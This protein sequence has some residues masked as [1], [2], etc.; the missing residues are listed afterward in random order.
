MAL[1]AR[2]R[3]GDAG[4]LKSS[5]RVGTAVELF[6]ADVQDLI[7]QDVLAPNTYQTYRYQYDKNLAPRVS[8][9]RLDELTTPRINGVIKAI[10]DEVG[11]ATA[12]TCRTIVSRTCALAVTHGALTANPVREITIR[13]TSKK[14]PPRALEGDEL[15]QWF[16]LL[17][18]DERAVRADL[19]DISKFMVATG[20]RIGETLAV[21]WRDVNLETGEVDCSHQIQRVKE[22]GLVRRRVKSVA[23]D[24]VLGLPPWAVEM[25]EARWSAGISPDAPIFPDSKGGFRDPHNVQKAL[26]D[27]RRPVGSQRRLELGKRL[28]DHRVAAGLTQVQAVEKLGWRKTRISL[29]ETGRVR[30]AVEEVQSLASAY[31]LS[32]PDRTAL[33]ELTELAGLR[34][35]ADELEWVTA[36]SMRKSTATILEDA[37]QTPRQVADQLGHAQTSTTVDDYFGRRRRNPD[38]AQHLEAAMRDVHERYQSPRDPEL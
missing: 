38:A 3:I 5:D 35:L 36:H 30:L 10:R 23:G 29:L 17:S 7:A 6:L 15:D 12:K 19:I 1:K 33:L 31:N 18:K 16:E 14:K 9:L 2:Q 11:A 34:S 20:E 32:R 27:A 24:R 26:R 22:R 37:G 21:T 25:L 13:A 28:R 4:G 8:E